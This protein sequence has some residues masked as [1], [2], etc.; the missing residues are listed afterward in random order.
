VA[1][2]DRKVLAW[3]LVAAAAGA[4]GVG[5]GWTGWLVATALIAVAV[6]VFLG[7]AAAASEA[8]SAALAKAEEMV[9]D[10]PGNAEGVVAAAEAAI[11]GAEIQ[12]C[13][14]GGIDNG[15]APDGARCHSRA[16]RLRTALCSEFPEGGCPFTLDYVAAVLSAPSKKNPKQPRSFRY[17]L[18]KLTKALRWRQSLDVSALSDATHG[19]GCGSL[20]WRGYDKHR[21]PILWV[22]PPRKDWKRLDLDGEVELHVS[23]IEYGISIMP[24][25]VSTFTV[26]AN[27]KG[28]GFAH[29]NA[30]FA[31]MMLKLITTGYPDRLGALYAGP[32]NMALRSIF[33]LLSP[34]M[35]QNLAAKVNLV[36]SMAATLSDVCGPEAVPDFF[37]GP[38]DHAMALEAGGAFSVDTM[39]T[40]ME[41][42]LSG[43]PQ[44]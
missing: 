34:L 13:P 21:R 17:A 24:P 4:L 35:P 3:Q 44:E 22:H 28:L 6:H 7:A 1:Y 8:G 37:D 43:L 31:K 18:Q 32:V 15:A 20:Y 33:S 10:R 16:D 38:R 9:D 14:D 23:I 29:I 25:G 42:D 40:S 26:V 2:A 27:T 36:G 5:I 12:E 19:I 39:K 41:D 11:G 30:S